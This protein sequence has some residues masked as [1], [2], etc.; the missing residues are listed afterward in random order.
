M[1]AHAGQN[2]TIHNRPQ[3]LSIRTMSRAVAHGS[4]S[5]T[6]G[7]SIAESMMNASMRGVRS[8][9]YANAFTS[10]PRPETR[11]V[12]S[13]T[14]PSARAGAAAWP[15]YER[16]TGRPGPSRDC[17]PGDPMA[18]QQHVRR[19]SGRRYSSFRQSVRIRPDR[20]AQVFSLQAC[21]AGSSATSRLAWRAPDT[22]PLAG[23]AG[24]GPP[25]TDAVDD[26]AA[27]ASYE[28]KSKA[29]RAGETGS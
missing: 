28:V 22:D 25:H 15:G 27:A 20:W 18:T 3:T 23:E 19:R 5:P 29:A 12:R 24:I 13:D 4:N 1:D 8:L 16:G 2:P 11:R 10:R 7:S 6:T 9:L 17:S 21:F 26:R 14:G